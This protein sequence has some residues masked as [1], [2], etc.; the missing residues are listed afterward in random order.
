MIKTRHWLFAFL[1]AVSVQVMAVMYSNTLQKDG[2]KDEGLQ[3]I[4]IDLGMMGDLG[5][6]EDD[7]EEVVPEPE[8]TTPPE[9]EKI[10]DIVEEPEPIKEVEKPVRQPKPVVEEKQQNTV[11]VKQVKP[12]LI[13]PVEHAQVQ[14]PEPV[15]VSV[16]IKKTTEKV[17][18]KKVVA[19]RK[20]T[21]GQAEDTHSGGSKAINPSYF[22]KLASALA[23]HK[24]YPIS[25]R[26]SGEEG[27]VK[28]YFVIDRQGKVLDFR[29]AESSGFD[30]LDQAVIKMLKKAQPLP[31]FTADMTMPKLEITV[32]IAFKL[33]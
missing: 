15:P 29:I 28:L 4:E 16:P 9:L 32:P 14:Q 20:K 13:K 27:I 11:K 8:E 31:A 12:D 26:R 23:K 7:I 24:R 25:A 10:E 30:R 5:V 2:A 19:E 21:T 3:G 6:S 22:S 33:N 1:L 18:E 17:A